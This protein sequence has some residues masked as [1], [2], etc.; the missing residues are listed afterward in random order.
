MMPIIYGLTASAVGLQ[1][2]L[3]FASVIPLTFAASVPF[4]F[5]WAMRKPA[6]EPVETLT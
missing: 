4:L 5:R 2:T 3:V 6:A 1:M